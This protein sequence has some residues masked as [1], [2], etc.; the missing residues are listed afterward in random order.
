MCSAVSQ[1]P[2]LCGPSTSPC[3]RQPLACEQ[4]QPRPWGAVQLLAAPPRWWA[5]AAGPPALLPCSQSLSWEAAPAETGR[6]KVSVWWRQHRR[7][8]R[9]QGLCGQ[10]MYSVT[11]LLCDLVRVWPQVLHTLSGRQGWPA[12]QCTHFTDELDC[13]LDTSMTGRSQWPGGMWG[14]IAFYGVWE[15]KG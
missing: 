5:A 8:G 4:R 2:N 1:G 11:E 12:S 6:P 9:G 10:I 13:G 14:A 3:L 15:H 7:V